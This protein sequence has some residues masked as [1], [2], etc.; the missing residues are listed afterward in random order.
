[1]RSHLSAPIA[2]LLPL[3][4]STPPVFGENLTSTEYLVHDSDLKIDWMR[5]GSWMPN[6]ALPQRKMSWDDAIAWLATLNENKYGGFNDWRLPTT[7]DGF[8][9]ENNTVIWKYN[10]N[11]ITTKYNVT[12]SELGHLFYSELNLKGYI[13]PSMESKANN[14]TYNTHYGL[15][16]A[17]TP[18]KGLQ[19]GYYWFG[20]PSQ[21]ESDMA[22]VFD[23]EFGIQ[24]LQTKTMPNAYAIA[25]RSSTP[26]PAPEPGTALLFLSGLTGTLWQLRRKRK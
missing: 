12:V 8:W 25:V 24:F 13:A 5:D 9:E 19:S 3:F 2:L 20:T 18:F 15:G 10:N 6:D 7:P 4:L 21:S 26:T 14:I 22:W 16:N 17:S 1:M 11:D 23:F